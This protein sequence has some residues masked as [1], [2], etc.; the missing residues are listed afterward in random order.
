MCKTTCKVT[1]KPWFHIILQNF[2]SSPTKITDTKS[3]SV[4]SIKADN[5]VRN[6]VCVEKTRVNNISEKKRF[7]LR[8]QQ[9]H[10]TSQ[11]L[12]QSQIIKIPLLPK[13]NIWT[14]SIAQ[15]SWDCS[16]HVMVTESQHI[17]TFCVCNVYWEWP[18]VCRQIC[19]VCKMR[20][21]RNHNSLWI[22]S[23]H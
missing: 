17:Q 18:T 14:Y 1:P 13:W 21:T 19:H 23:I 3:S 20:N 6:L 12:T 4:S 9:L 22:T 7:F 8:D 11:G 16:I 15:I 2:I 10:S 5:I